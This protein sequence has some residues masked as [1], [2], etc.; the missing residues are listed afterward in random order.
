MFLSREDMIK[1]QIDPVNQTRQPL[2][3]TAIPSYK[4]RS[5]QEM[6]FPEAKYNRTTLVHMRLLKCNMQDNIYA[7]VNNYRVSRTKPSVPSD[8]AINSKTFRLSLSWAFCNSTNPSLSSSFVINTS[9]CK[10]KN[11]FMIASTASKSRCVES[12]RISACMNLFKLCNDVRDRTSS[13]SAAGCNILAWWKNASSKSSL[14]TPQAYTGEKGTH[15]PHW[16]LLPVAF[17]G[18]HSRYPR[19]LYLVFA[20]VFLFPSLVY[21]RERIVYPPQ[22]KLEGKMAPFLWVLV[23]LLVYFVVVSPRG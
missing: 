18:T 5:T 20:S 14:N 17:C 10:R 2:H 15:N 9:A 7:T 4:T 1:T 21:P 16:D 23:V 11:T 13:S 6:A 22:A 19:Q 3:C 8:D 12:R